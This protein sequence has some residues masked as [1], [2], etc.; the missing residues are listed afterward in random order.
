MIPTPNASLTP[1]PDA[2]EHNAR[3]HPKHADLDTLIHSGVVTHLIPVEDTVDPLYAVGQ[4]RTLP[5]VT[6]AAAFKDGLIALGCDQELPEALRKIARPALPVGLHVPPGPDA[7]AEMDENALRMEKLIDQFETLIFAGLPDPD[8]EPDTQILLDRFTSLETAIK[9]RTA[10]QKAPDLKS[11]KEQITGLHRRLDQLDQ[12]AQQAQDLPSLAESIAQIDQT[13]GQLA[14]DIPDKDSQI[15][16]QQDLK[17]LL[18]RPMPDLDLASQQ[19]SFEQFQ[20]VLSMSIQRIEKLAGDIKGAAPKGKVDD[21]F[22]LLNSR[23]DDLVRDQ[24]MTAK[25]GT[26]RVE[27]AL[28]GLAALTQPVSSTLADLN[29]KLE[30]VVSRPDPKFPEFET[31]LD[32]IEQLLGRADIAPELANHHQAFTAFADTMQ[33]TITEITTQTQALTARTPDQIQQ[34][35]DLMSAVNSLPELFE[36]MLRQHVDLKELETALADANSGIR[37]LP[38]QI[39]KS[40]LGEWLAQLAQRPDPL[41]DLNIQRQNIARFG[42]TLALIVDRLD[43]LSGNIAAAE[44][45]EQGV[46]PLAEAVHRIETRIHQL[47]SRPISK[48]HPETETQSHETH[49]QGSGP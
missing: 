1:D 30:R 28:D 26:Q 5:E 24:R 41:P 20:T 18:A 48:Q 29:S 15:S 22:S 43:R 37:Q 21:H 11:L 8:R 40:H 27:T 3:C 47:A 14:T 4:M 23:L 6:F 12:A 38:D 42:T 39:D 44:A 31:I 46:T 2:T 35:A 33:E 9:A 13:L 16:L 49:F 34:G 7:R 19:Q 25:T 10:P 45:R 17:A 36:T 32:Q